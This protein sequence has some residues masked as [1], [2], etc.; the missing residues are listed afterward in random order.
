MILIAPPSEYGGVIRITDFITD[1][2]VV[3]I[4]KITIFCVI[5]LS[6]TLGNDIKSKVDQTNH[7]GCW[8]EGKFRGGFLPK[9]IVLFSH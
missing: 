6:Y 5:F 3:G 4:G 8:D 9:K 7:P 1:I 2:F